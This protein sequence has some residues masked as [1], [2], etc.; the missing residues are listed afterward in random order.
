ME[1][2]TWDIITIMKTVMYINNFVI[3][4]FIIF[5]RYLI[6]RKRQKDIKNYLV[7]LRA[8]FLI[9]Q[10]LS[11]YMNLEKTAHQYKYSR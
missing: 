4:V 8:A 1:A 9:H 5:F 6:A 2:I 7:N 3:T 11:N 10:L